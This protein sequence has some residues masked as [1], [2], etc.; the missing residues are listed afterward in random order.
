[1]PFRVCNGSHTVLCF[2]SENMVK[3]IKVKVKSPN[4]VQTQKVA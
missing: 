1:L 3:I 4:V 2:R